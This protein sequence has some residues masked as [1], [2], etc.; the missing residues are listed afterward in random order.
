MSKMIYVL[1]MFQLLPSERVL[2]FFIHDIDVDH[3]GHYLEENFFNCWNLNS[4]VAS[5]I[6]TFDINHLIRT[7]HQIYCKLRLLIACIRIY[8]CCRAWFGNELKQDT[9]MFLN[10]IGGGTVKRNMISC[11]NEA[12]NGMVMFYVIIKQIQRYNE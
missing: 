2:E 10:L 3:V 5:L 7:N 1:N 8:T 9:D 11:G 12:S 4:S 6:Q